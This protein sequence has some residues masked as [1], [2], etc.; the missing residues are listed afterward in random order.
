MLFPSLRIGYLVVPP[1]LSSLC[2]QAKWLCDRQSP[3]LEQQVLADFIEQGHLERHIRRMRRLYDQ[4]RQAL[5]QALRKHLGQQVTILG[6]NAGIHLMVK[7]NTA[8]SDKTIVDRAA[9][10]GVGLATAQPYY[11]QGSAG[12]FLFGYSEL[13]EAQIQ[14]GIRRLA[15]VLASSPAFVSKLNKTHLD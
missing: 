13:S 3:L 15:Q 10:V 8:W 5:V 1:R 4:R 2:A 6:E 11:H 7:L 12:A 9:Q 14:D